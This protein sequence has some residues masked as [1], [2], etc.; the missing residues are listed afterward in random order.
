MTE[1]LDRRKQI[2]FEKWNVEPS[3]FFLFGKSMVFL[4]ISISWLKRDNS[5]Q[6][7]LTWRKTKC[8]N[9]NLNCN[10]T[11]QQK[12]HSTMLVYRIESRLIL[13]YPGNSSFNSNWIERSSS[14]S[15]RLRTTDL[16]IHFVLTSKLVNDSSTVLYNST[17]NNCKED[18]L[19]LTVNVCSFCIEVH[20]GSS[21]ID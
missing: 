21:Y 15:L 20:F 16:E 3:S 14:V 10:L 17:L 8:I 12:M 6:K 4:A 13:V 18:M 5:I 2:W 11:H 1:I 19:S 9:L 7:K